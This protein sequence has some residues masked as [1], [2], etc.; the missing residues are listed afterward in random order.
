M[1]SLHLLLPA[2]AAIIEPSSQ[3]TADVRDLPITRQGSGL[4]LNNTPWRAVGPNVYWLG[5]DE[6]VIPPSGQPFYAPFNASYPT[7]GRV[8]E[9]MSTVK[10][11]GG[12]TI[13]AHTL[14]VSTGNPLSVWPAEGVVNA[15]AFDAIDWAVAQAREYGVRLLVPLTDNYDYYHGGKYN[16]LRWAGFNLTQTSDANSLLVQQFYTN[17]TII[18]AFK[19][20]MRTLLTHV[21][22]YTNITYAQD[23]TIFAYETGNE[24]GGPVFGDMNV[25]VEW[26]R[27]IAGLVKELAPEKLVVDGTYGVNRSHFE[28]EGVDLLSDHFYPVNTTK[29]EE[30]LE[31]SELPKN[32]K[33]TRLGVTDCVI[34]ASAN[35]SYFAGE[36]DWVGSSDGD[37]LTEWFS[38]IKDSPVAGGD[39]FWSLFGHNVPDCNVSIVSFHLKRDY[40][41]TMRSP[42]S[43]S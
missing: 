2:L 17:A 41:L 37:S 9:I 25:P 16:F 35:R 40:I 12:T 20:Y 26:L 30:D 28:V 14:G 21:N 1:K 22:A 6:N 5:L 15:E 29:L 43:T 39:A 10:A 36:F 24:L 11:L 38:I 42:V 19:S 13:R 33:T 4:F 34:V 18:E 8:T 3:S 23:P 7:K 31:L 27:E 32:N